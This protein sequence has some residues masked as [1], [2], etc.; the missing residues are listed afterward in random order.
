[1]A[2]G[3]LNTL[4]P[5]YRLLDRYEIGAPL[6][7]GSASVRYAA[8]ADQT[9][10]I[11]EEYFPA[12]LASRRD[13]VEVAP[14]S[15]AQRDDFT[16]G[17][18]GF[19]ATARALA[20]IRDQ[21]IVPVLHW[22]DANGTGYVVIEDVDGET[23]A[24]R[25][26]HDT[27]L[28]DDE[29]KALMRPIIASLGTVH[30]A[31]LLHRQINPEAIVLRSDGT[32]MLCGF[33][34]GAK[35]V[36]GARQ[37]FDPRTATLAD[38][39]PGYTALEQYSTGGREGPWTDIYALGAVMYHCVT[40]AA[41]ADAPFRTVRAE[42]TPATLF[43]DTRDARMLAAIDAALAVPIASRPQSLPV[44]Q[45]MLFGDAQRTLAANRAG[46]TS[47]R[48]FGRAAVPS[49][50]SIA[51]PQV[52]DSPAS[53]TETTG[54]GRRLLRWAVPALAATAI[55]ALMTW[56]DTGVLRSRAALPP[57]GA[58]I[59][60]LGGEFSD[61][62]RSGGSG[63]A[64]VVVP[65]GSV[66]LGCFPADCP[67]PD[68]PPQEVAFDEP[69]AVA[70]H[71]VTEADYARFDAAS[72]P[73]RS[74]PGSTRLRPVA[75]VSWNDARAYTEWLSTET[76]RAYRL[77]TEAEWEY[78]ARAGAEVSQRMPEDVRTA[79]AELSRAAPVGIRPANAWGF[80]D[81]HG[82]VSE[83]TSDCGGEIQA[84]A[85]DGEQ[86]AP[87]CERR[88]RRGGWWGEPGA[89]KRMA[90]DAN[91]RNPDTGFRVAVRLD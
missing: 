51:L 48:G 73:Q 26:E 42:P 76:G 15:A 30:G 12:R 4:P 16:A 32:P 65:A 35:A 5:G 36:G 66:R 64:M 85:D 82:N 62:L 88:I 86:A 33:G 11:V 59:R 44:W 89:A 10:V 25:L 14:A 50:L 27:T 56:V 47:A 90:S 52:S 79:S 75:D 49:P 77:P 91:R 78:A 53:P 80:H 84:L 24:L 28:S 55:I 45:A 43:A 2:T 6:H 9:P 63:P 18:A 38:I 68:A 40:G 3:N 1:M 31:G 57:A 58:A 60:P 72:D 69:F 8:T 71:E 22:T 54:A 87:D 20:R 41:P 19:L 7:L 37:V 46:R 23:L 29:L 83:W 74:S 70:K 61:P 81:M 13:G 34:V 17:L 67:D 21:H 39:V